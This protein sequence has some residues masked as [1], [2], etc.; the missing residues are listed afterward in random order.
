[1]GQAEPQI[2]TKFALTQQGDPDQP[3]TLH[4]CKPAPQP[5]VLATERGLVHYRHYSGLSPRHPV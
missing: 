1:M 2:A 4:A 3:P 5:Y